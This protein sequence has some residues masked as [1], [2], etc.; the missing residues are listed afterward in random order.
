MA[1]DDEGEA[2][3]A[4]DARRLGFGLHVGYGLGVAPRDRQR[5]RDVEDVRFVAINPQ[6]RW[7]LARPGEGGR[8]YHGDLDGIVEASFLIETQPTSGWAGGVNFDLR[9]RFL[10]DAS[11]Q[12]YIEAGVGVGSLD[13]GLTSQADGLSFVLQAGAGARVRL[14]ERFSLIGGI[15]WHHISNAQLRQP[16]NGIDDILFLVG[17]ELW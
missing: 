15:R 4:Q 3:P 6:L 7:L 13:F 10:R 11:V 14:D 1:M 17:V 2:S 5:G 16:N 8:W 9:Y 12:P